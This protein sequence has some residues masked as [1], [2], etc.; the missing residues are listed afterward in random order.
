MN[1]AQIIIFEMDL[2]VLAVLLY[3]LAVKIS[4]LNVV[5]EFINPSVAPMTAK[6]NA[7]RA[8]KLVTLG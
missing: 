7:V 8:R 4:Q 2:P 1:V 3:L 5:K 6:I